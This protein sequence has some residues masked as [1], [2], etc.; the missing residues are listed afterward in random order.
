M[1]IIIDLNDFQSMVS[2][3]GYAGTKELTDA[4]V[5]LCLS[6]I[7]NAE[8]SEHWLGAFYELTQFEQDEIDEIVANAKAELM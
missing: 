5:L 3:G 6:F 4:T 7:L 2:D 8:S 1:A